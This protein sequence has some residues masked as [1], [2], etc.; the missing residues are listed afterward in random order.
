MS[1]NYQLWKGFHDP[2]LLPLLERAWL[3]EHLLILLPPRLE[4]Q[5]FLKELQKIDLSPYVLG[6][7]TS[8]TSSGRP[9]L[10]LYTRKN[11]ESSIQSV[12]GLFDTNRI[13]NL[14]CYPH[15]FHT[16]GLILG[17]MASILKGW[18][19]YPLNGRYSQSFH[20]ERLHIT[21]ERTL[22]LG[23]PAHFRDLIHHLEK[24]KRSIFPSYS[25]IV[26]G[27]PVRVDLWNQ[28]RERLKIESPSIGYGATEASPAVTH[29]APG[30]T[31]H[32]DGEIGSPLAHLEV[33]IQEDGLYFRGDSVCGAIL[34]EDTW[35]HPKEILLKD[36]IEKTWDGRWIFKERLDLVLNRGGEKFSLE[37]IESFIWEKFRIEAAAVCVPDERLG[38]ELGILLVEDSHQASEFKFEELQDYFKCRFNPSL[39]RSVKQLPRNSSYKIHRQACLEIFFLFYQWAKAL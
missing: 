11:I 37:A 24:E 33:R 20:D 27:A 34:D 23:A 29:L 3:G 25:C 19:L 1:K 35:I 17:Y 10:V 4:D 8:G 30:K 18:E 13:Q 36:K 26:G 39:V 9:K 28:I 7:F 31:P 16:F 2:K 12:Y 14:F 5:S 32:S 6:V 38:F 15:P 21:D 22:T